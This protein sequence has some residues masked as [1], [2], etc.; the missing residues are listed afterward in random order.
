MPIKG[1]LV[2]VY[3]PNYSLWIPRDGVHVKV[4]GHNQRWIAKYKYVQE[5]DTRLWSVQ[6]EDAGD[7]L[8]WNSS[9]QVLM[10]DIEHWWRVVFIG[11]SVVFQVPHVSKD[12]HSYY[13]LHLEDDE[14][15]MWPVD[16]GTILF[17]TL[18]VGHPQEQPGTAPRQAAVDSRG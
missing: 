4:K 17:L 14:S 16:R 2:N 5:T 12:D 15:V 9:M 3:D 10:S 8:S 11:A 13:T 7:Y 18:V 1:V 6:A